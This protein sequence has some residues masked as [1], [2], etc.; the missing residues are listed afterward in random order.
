LDDAALSLCDGMA[1][2]G[3]EGAI[4]IAPSLSAPPW[5]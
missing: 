2:R 1:Q 3:E 5:Q 4:E